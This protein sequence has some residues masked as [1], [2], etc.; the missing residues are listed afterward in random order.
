MKKEEEEE[1]W[2]L[3]C[4]AVLAVGF[5]THRNDRTAADGGGVMHQ[6]TSGWSG[7][8]VSASVSRILGGGFDPLKWR[9]VSGGVEFLLFIQIFLIFQ[10]FTK[11]CRFFPDFLE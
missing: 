3:A 8:N 5:T 2:R 7:L 1:C 10:N 4:S 9:A 11:N 6:P